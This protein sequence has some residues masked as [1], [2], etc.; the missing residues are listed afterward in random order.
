MTGPI[1]LQ[2]QVIELLHLEALAA[3]GGLLGV[4]DPGLLDSALA[5]P[6]NRH[7]YEGETDL[8][9][10]AA[11]V[12]SSIVRN[13]PFSDGNK[14]TAFIAAVVVLDLNGLVLDAPNRPRRHARPRRRRPAG[15]GLRPLVA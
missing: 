12:A 11:C 3:H 10:L 8:V 5:R 4:R 15:G 7:A 6:L 2:R 13:H 9:R 14:R 1:W